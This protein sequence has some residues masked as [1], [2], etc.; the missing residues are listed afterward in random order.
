MQ[1]RRFL[2][3]RL[4][5]LSGPDAASVRQ[6]FVALAISLLASL[7]AGLTLGAITGTLEE[8]PGLLILIPAAIGLRGTVFGALGARLGTSIHAGTFR[9]STRPQTVLGQNVLAA[10]ALTVFA[11]VA[12]GILAKT[13]SV[14][15]GLEDSISVDDFV[16][17]SLV[18]G[19]LSSLVVLVLTVLLAAGSVRYDWDPD[20]VT[21]PLVTASGDMVTLPS[22]FLATYL[23][24]IELVTPVLAGLGVIGATVAIVAG[25]SSGL[26]ITR[27]VVRESMVVVVGAGILS[28]IAGQTLQERLDDLAGFPALLALVPP[29]LAAAGAIGGILSS[30]LTSKLHLGLLEPAAVPGRLAR[31]DVRFAYVVGFPVFVG[32]SLVADIAAALVDLRS[33]G[34]VDM[35]LVAVVGGFMV[36]SLAIAIAYYG[37][38][39]SYRM[40]VDPDNVG[41]PL[42]TSS[43]DLLGAICFILAVV[44]VGV[45]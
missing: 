34:P 24:D 31:E 7:V 5:A 3:A 10:A 16:V 28:L 42:V 26:T 29:F 20:N 27:R 21:A 37:A 25:A 9:V 39:V 19:A 40:G 6:S 33:P 38:I 1:W 36:T 41:I 17:I 4:R 30:R 14:G 8:L 15:F 22:L 35:A 2:R 23:V 43:L 12:L 44:A 11:S 13:V 32:A 45:V 18:G